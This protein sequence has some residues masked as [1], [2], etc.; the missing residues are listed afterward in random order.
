MDVQQTDG[1]F[2]ITTEHGEAEL[3]YRLEGDIMA[4]YHT[5]TPEGERGKGIAE[6]L[7]QAAFAFAVEK[8][9]M[10][11]PD[12]PYIVHYLEKHPEMASHAV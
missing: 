7:A 6:A 8:N 3:L 9:F 1:R 2:Y 4:I 12:C 10:V 5:Y 11:R